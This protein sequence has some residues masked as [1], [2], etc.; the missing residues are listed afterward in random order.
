MTYG[1]HPLAPWVGGVV[2]MVDSAKEIAGFIKEVRSKTGSE[3]VDLVGHS[4]GGVMTLY[5]P[6]TQEGIKD[7]VEHT[8]ALGPA[9]HGAR[10]YGF[11]DLFY[12]GG[13][14][15]RTLAGDVLSVLGC[16]ACDDMAIGGRVYSD[17]ADAAGHIVQD[18]VKASIVMSRSDTLVTPDVSEVNETGVRNLFVQDYCPDD[19]VGYAGLAW[20]TGV[21]DIIINE[22]KENYEGPVGCTQ[23]LTF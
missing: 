14:E 22:L 18:G 6:L 8:V 13:Q 11:T 1:V 15:T 19:T 5:V 16:E 7:I 17:F 12:L 3:K 20:D 2:S 4:E 9:V 23:G 10:Y 21:W